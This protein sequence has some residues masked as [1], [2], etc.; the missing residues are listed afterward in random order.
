MTIEIGYVLIFQNCRS[1][2]VDAKHGAE[3]DGA[4]LGT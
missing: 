3:K 4:L 2:I 1:I